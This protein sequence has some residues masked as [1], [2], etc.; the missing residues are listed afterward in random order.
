ML[1]MTK[2][3]L[4][5]LPGSDM[6]GGVS[7]ISNRCSKANNNYWKSCD[8]KQELRHNIYLDTNN[9]YSYAMSNSLPTSGLK[10]IDPKEFNLNKYT[11]NS[12]K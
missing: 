4:E 11:S 7:C 9:L 10:W 2:L 8:P 5:L 6:K 1:N 12:S 3:G